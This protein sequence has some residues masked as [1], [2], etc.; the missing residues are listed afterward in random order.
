MCNQ[1]RTG[2]T[3]QTVR[4]LEIP[5][6]PVKPG[7]SGVEQNLIYPPET[8]DG[9]RGIKIIAQRNNGAER[10]A[11]EMQEGLKNGF[12][13]VDIT[14]EQFTVDQ[15]LELTKSL[16]KR[17]VNVTGQDVVYACYMRIDDAGDKTN[18]RQKYGKD[19]ADLLTDPEIAKQLAAG[20]L[21]FAQFG[22][23]TTYP[24]KMQAM[25]KGTSESKV[26]RFGNILKNLA[27]NGIMSHVFVIV[28]YPLRES[29]W[30]DGNKF[31]FEQE[32]LGRNVD[33]DDLEIL[34]VVYNLKF[35]HDNRDY[36]YTF[37]Q[38]PYELAYG[39]PMATRP[40]EF[41]L[42]ADWEKFGKHRFIIQHSFSIML[43]PV[44]LPY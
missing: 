31:A 13:V 20:G 9:K 44:L 22:L 1:Q 19:L 32:V 23:E 27:E 25:V 29:Y 15:A 11:D 36:I 4:R 24:P 30:K 35:L 33:A 28:G 12:S 41:G 39:S 3:R 43:L 16:A 42:K 37:K 8:V 2:R 5:Q 6:R 17:G 7:I 18:Y 26:K 10:M 40:D 34:E 14:D 21:R 38:A